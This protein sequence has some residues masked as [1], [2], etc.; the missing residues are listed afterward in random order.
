MSRI[1]RLSMVRSIFSNTRS[2]LVCSITTHDPSFVSHTSVRLFMPWHHLYTN[3]GGGSVSAGLIQFGNKCRLSDSYQMYW[4]RYA[5]VI[6]SSGSI[7]YTGMRCEYRSMN[8]M[9]TSLNARC[10]SRCRLM[11]DSASCGLS[12]ACSIKPSSSR[13]LWF[14]LA[15]MEK[16][17]FKRSSAKIKSLRSCLYDS[18]GNGMGENFL[19]SNQCTVV[20]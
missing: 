8:S 19:D 12:N 16:F 20:V 6:F 7:S 17:S 18:G 2:N 5:S 10:V 13:W 14:S 15:A 4:S 11:R 1:K 3:K 9:P